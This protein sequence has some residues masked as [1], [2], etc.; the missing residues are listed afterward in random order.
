MERMP[1]S[2]SSSKDCAACVAN[3]GTWARTAAKGTT[4]AEITIVEDSKGSK[5]EE[6]NSTGPKEVEDMDVDRKG[7]TVDMKR[8]TSQI[9]VSRASASIV[10]SKATWPPIAD[11]NHDRMMTEETKL[12][13][14]K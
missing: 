10:G 12:M 5:E 13:K 8:T 1:R 4:K 11:P 7:S 14:E 2:P 9:D 3:M 6:T